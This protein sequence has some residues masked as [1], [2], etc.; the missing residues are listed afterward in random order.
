MRRP[1]GSRGANSLFSPALVVGALAGALLTGLVAFWVFYDRTGTDIVD[2]LYRLAGHERVDRPNQRN[3]GWY[4]Y[5]GGGTRDGAGDA[6][7]GQKANSDA[8]PAAGQAEPLAADWG[9]VVSPTN[10][11]WLVRRGYDV[12][13]VADGFTYPV[14]IVFVLEPGPDADDPLYYVNELHGT[15]KFVTRSGE[16]GTYATKLNNF[17]PIPQ[18]KSDETGL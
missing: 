6:D 15:I 9:G 11:I 18:P 1:R 14:N 12:Q 13:R 7:P 3:K 17:R 16:V 10:P 8:K 2:R 4:G 5:E